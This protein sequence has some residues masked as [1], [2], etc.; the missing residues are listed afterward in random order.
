L[1]AI[2][3]RCAA[4]DQGRDI[5]LNI[6]IIG[7]GGWGRRLVESVQGRSDKLRFTAAVVARPEKSKDF[8]VQHGL[9]VGGDLAAMLVDK[10]VQAVVSTGPVGLHATHSLAAIEA[11]KP[12]LAVK[13]M[14]IRK[15]DAEKL[16]AAATKRGVLLAMGYNRCFYPSVDALRRRVARGDL[17]KLLHIEGDFCVDRYF[18][19]KPGDWK[20]DKT[21]VVP[22]ALADHQLYG[23]I[24]LMGRVAEV[25][26][27]ASRRAVSVD[28]ADT[29]AVLL[30]FEN[31][32]SGLLT[33]IGATA[34]YERL[35]VF[36]DK[37]CAEI[38]D[39]NRLEYRPLTGKAETQDFPDFDAEKAEMEAFAE[40]VVGRRP[41]PVPVATAVHSV[42][43]IEAM[44][45]SAASGKPVAP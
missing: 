9:A 13:P 15:A 21:Q 40:A 18:K 33:A 31:G 27:Q 4:P 2:L 35:A 41:F 22:G 45:K 11:G 32:A 19:A 5:V 6:G 24:E 39:G 23:S 20:A 37:G 36:G 42:A 1:S 14:A 7:L 12:V 28:L 29:T 25:A 17:G 26:V 38:R 43:V 16:A 10:S 44:G 8:A 34:T 3:R 30:R